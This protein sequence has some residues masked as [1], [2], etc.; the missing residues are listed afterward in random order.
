[1]LQQIDGIVTT[2]VSNVLYLTIDR[3]ADMN[4]LSPDLVEQLG[5][6]VAALRDDQETHVL[7]ITGRGDDF[8]SMGLLNPAIRAS[9]SKDDVIRLV[10][11]ANAVFDA[12]EALPQITIAAINGKIMAGAVEL[13]LACDL[14]Y[15]VTHATMQMPE[16]SWGGFPGAGAPVRLPQ[17]VGKARAL[18]L[19]CTAREVD[20]AE[21]SQLGLIQ[22]LYPQ[23]TFRDEVAKTAQT[24]ANNGPLA[25]R[26]AKRIMATRQEPGTRAARE[27]SDALR[28]ALEWSQDVD[29]GMAAHKANRKPNFIGR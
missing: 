11:K 1:M 23:A 3:P 18:E 8:F 22:G 16:A 14:R 7:V 21:M 20:S 2:R 26:G 29:E 12:L 28:H 15:A 6:I 25:T 4:R 17:L 5:H 13:S 10:R 19:I 27:L 9:L 24:I